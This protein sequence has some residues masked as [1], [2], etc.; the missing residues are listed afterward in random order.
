MVY[1]IAKLLA[2]SVMVLALS[3]SGCLASHGP[4]VPPD[5]IMGEFAGTLTTPDGKAVKAEVKLIADEDSKYRVVLLF[6]AGNAKAQR[7]ELNGRGKDGVVSVQ[8]Q[9]WSGKITKEAVSLESAKAGKAEM[10]RVE[11]K[12]PT[13]GQKPPSDALI[14]LPFEEGKTTILDNWANKHWICEPDGSVLVRQGD[15]KS[16]RDFGSYKL[17]VEFRV[18]FM[19]SARGQGR[20]HSGVYQHGRY[21]IQVLD[22]FGLTADAGDCGAIYGK[23][24]PG[25]NASLPPG[26]W[27][28]YDIEFRAPEF[29]AAGHQT[30]GAVISV[31]HNG[32]KIHDAV[33]VDGVT[34][35][36]WGQPAKTGPVRLQDHGGDPTRFRNIWIVEEK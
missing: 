33:V 8:D 12:S 9:G 22:S 1:R 30:K 26:Q 6:P 31:A 3:A 16:L 14:L 28:T 2:C 5:P 34:G 10:T 18:P 17:H 20:G 13:L 25:V 19:P 27:Q 35:G 11:R 24:A 32:V 7:I 29:D 36:A 15:N 21:E 4:E 23:K